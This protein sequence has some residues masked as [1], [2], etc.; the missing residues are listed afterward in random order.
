MTLAVIFWD[1]AKVLVFASQKADQLGD[2][3]ANRFA[4]KHAR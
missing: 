2:R 4:E 3:A 1:L